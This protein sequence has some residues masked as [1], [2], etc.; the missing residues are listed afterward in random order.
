MDTLED[1]EIEKRGPKLRSKDTV[2][3][4]INPKCPKFFFPI[5]TMFHFHVI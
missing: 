1:K 3:L 5:E 2:I 4:D